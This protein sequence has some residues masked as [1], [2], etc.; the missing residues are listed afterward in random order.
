MAVVGQMFGNRPAEK[1]RKRWL[2]AVKEDSYQ[3]L[4]WRDWEVKAQDREE[5][6]LRIKKANARFGL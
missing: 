1:P 2:D 5:Y 6:R 3:I 4:K